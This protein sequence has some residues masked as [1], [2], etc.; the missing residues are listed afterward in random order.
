MQSTRQKI[1]ALST[2]EA[3]YIA[4]CDTSKEVV[5]I[6]RLMESVGAADDSATQL[7]LDNQGSVKFIKNPEF[8]KRTKYI[9][10]RFHFIREVYSTGH[11][12]IKYVPSSR[13]LADILTKA[14]PRNKFE[15]NR[16]GLQIMVVEAGQTFNWWECCI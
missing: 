3:E 7:R 11:I 8:H 2:T 10:V 16:T 4:A 12:K 6:R 13:Q 14:L 1:V 15:T 5:W 9:D